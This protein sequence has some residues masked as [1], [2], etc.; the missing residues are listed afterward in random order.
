MVP[1]VH[2]APAGD[3]PETVDEA[4]LV[5]AVDT[6]PPLGWG[7][8]SGPGLSRA[9]HQRLTWLS[10]T[11]RQLRARATLP[12]AE[13]VVEVT[14]AL[15]LDIEVA[16]RPNV[17]PAGARTHLDAF[18]QVAVGF[19]NTADRA[20]LPAF[21]AWLAAAEERE[22]GLQPG[23]S[24]SAEVEVTDGEGPPSDVEVSRGAV[25]LLTVH[26]AKGL[27][28]DVVA[29]P[30]LVEGIL[31]I[32]TVTAKHD[33]VDWACGPDTDSG[34]RTIA[35]GGLMPY[36]LRGDADSLPVLELAEQG[37]TKDLEQ[38]L[39]DF[40]ASCGRAAVAEERRLAYVA[41]TRAKEALLLTA[42]VWGTP[43][44]TPRV[45]SRFVDE[46]LAAPASSPTIRAL[47]G[48]APMPDPDPDLANPAPADRASAAWPIDPL[49]ERRAAMQT[50]ADAVRRALAASQRLVE[51][52]AGSPWAAEID[53]LLAER[54]R[55]RNPEVLVT[56]PTH[57]S[58][59]RL[60]RLAENPAA[61]AGELRRP[62]PRPPAPEARRGTAFHAWIEQRYGAAAMVDILEL[63]GSADEAP[64]ADD[65]LPQLQ[66]NFL[67]SEWAD[68]TPAEIEV[69]IETPVA[70]TVIRGRIDAVFPVG[71]DPD[72]PRWDVVDWKTGA[73]P[74]GAAATARAVQLAAYRL[75]WA[76]LQGVS[77]D[78]VGAA[79]FYA[80]SG[81]T[82]RPVDL[83]DETALTALVT[84]EAA[85]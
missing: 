12:L 76:R 41:Y 42:H 20:T 2:Q 75:A 7:D 53:L 43:T 45:T 79:F 6:L 84:G 24:E 55:S 26:A 64:A 78:R 28:W 66:A 3:R 35:K 51:G 10:R 72:D 19:A 27:E 58:A 37:D 67:D 71:S 31:P 39:V 36:G 65:L 32:R 17:S 85:Q 11:L 34:W 70:G 4:S 48:W 13:L 33:G 61:L 54:D 77:V 81:T 56:L 30:G 40:E 38:H 46:L 16:S 15:R 14:R 74:H 52:G 63:P 9:A 60:V 73:E 49:G 83:L 44:R 22:R 18:E 59:S 21:L 62:M 50:A 8:G 68:R 80:A 29:V 69:A 5:E 47:P 1:T 25:Q 82:V 57:L 23:Q